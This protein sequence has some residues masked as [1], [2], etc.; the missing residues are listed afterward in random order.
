M[1]WEKRR[2]ASIGSKPCL[3]LHQTVEIW[4][5]SFSTRLRHPQ[6]GKERYHRSFLPTA[7]RLLN[8]A[9]W[10]SH[11]LPRAISAFIMRK[12]PTYVKCCSCS[13]WPLYTHKSWARCLFIF[14]LYFSCKSCKWLLFSALYAAAET[15][16][17]PHCRIINIFCS[18]LFYLNCWDCHKVDKCFW[19][20]F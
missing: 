16:Q 14:I 13:A 3:P 6:C 18:I 1:F 17:F 9:S 11:N 12:K 15:L 19:C 2:L 7:I 5:S 10:P 20:I 8:A 4:G